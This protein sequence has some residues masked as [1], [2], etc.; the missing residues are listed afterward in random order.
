MLVVLTFGFDKGFRIK[1]VEYWCDGSE[2]LCFIHGTH[3]L[4]TIFGAYEV[5]IFYIMI[6]EDEALNYFYLMISVLFEE[7][8]LV[9]TIL[10]L[11]KFCKG[12]I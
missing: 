8:I 12:Q 10:Y 2:F 6:Y 4:L 11:P 1:L 5:N 3:G 9:L 7:D